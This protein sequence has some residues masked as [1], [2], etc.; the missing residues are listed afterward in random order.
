MNAIVVY[1]SVYGNTREV[2][3]AIAEGVGDA[4]VFPVHEAANDVRGYELVVVGGPTHMHGMAS[5]SS[6]HA[7]V[8]ALHEDGNAHRVEPGATEEPG[9]RA[10]LRD[11]AEGPEVRAATF[12]T[13]LDR[14]PWLTGAASRG[15]AKRLRHRRYEVVDSES[16]LVEESEGPLADGEVDR[17]REWGR[18]LASMMPVGATPSRVS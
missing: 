2:A 10:W 4:R 1:E 8:E 15:I 14:S 7:A 3:E 17:A 13:R 11:L 6:R 12:D 5:S 18:K 16:F 9:L